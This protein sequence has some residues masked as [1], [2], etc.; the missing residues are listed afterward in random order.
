MRGS[1]PRRG[2]VASL[3]LLAALL[4]PVAPQAAED[5]VRSLLRELWIQVPSRVVMAPAF[6]L[7]DLNGKPVRLADHKGRPVMLYF[8]T[9]Y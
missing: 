8:W 4:A 6:S 3:A 7:P 5:E 2:V 9:T 1:S